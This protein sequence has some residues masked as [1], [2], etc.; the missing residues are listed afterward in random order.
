MDLDP[1][2]LF[3]GFLFGMVGMGYF[4]FGKKRGSYLF[5]G[6]GMGLGLFPYFVDALWAILL[7]GAFLT[8]LPFVIK[9]D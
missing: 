1:G 8:A 5:M 9:G 2:K 4:M 6:S 7:V 3:I